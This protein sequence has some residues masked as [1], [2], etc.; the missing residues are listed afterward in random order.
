ML[1]SCQDVEAVLECRRLAYTPIT[2]LLNIGSSVVSDSFKSIRLEAFC[3]AHNDSFRRFCKFRRTPTLS[4][5][6]VG[7]IIIVLIK[8]S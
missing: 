5:H 6:L 7:L 4:N 1:R 8:A 3:H 2:V